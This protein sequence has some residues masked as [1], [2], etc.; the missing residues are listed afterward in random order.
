MI[1]GR[2]IVNSAG[3]KMALQPYDDGQ[4]AEVHVEAL[5]AN[6]GPVFIG[7]DTVVAHEDG[8]SSL[9]LQPGDRL[10]VIRN[11]ELLELWVDAQNDGDGIVWMAH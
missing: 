11:I 2:T 10:P 8:F 9:P 6:T 1:T 7:I 3:S 4:R 5:A